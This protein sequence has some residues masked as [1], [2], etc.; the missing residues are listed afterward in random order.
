MEATIFTENNTP[1][2][3]VL[4]GIFLMLFMGIILVLFFYFSKKKIIQKELEKKENELQHSKDLLEASIAVQE[5]ERRRIAQDLHD[6]ISSKLNVV[7]LN[8]HLLSIDNLEKEKQTEILNTILS[9]S[10]KALDS[11]RRIAHNLFP[12]VFD[13][14]GLDAAIEELCSEFSSLENVNVTYKSQVTFNEADKERHLH[15][16]RI[17]QELINNSVRHGKSK[18]ITIIFT[19][20]SNKI[21]CS[22]NDNGVGFNLD[23]AEKQAGLGMKNIES[24]INFLKGTLKFESSINKG[25]NAIFEF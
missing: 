25:M 19:N 4:T 8:C 10:T 9:L 18:K 11:S 1:A 17:L 16:F 2:I 12:P 23:R 22:Y 14:F 15:V 21:S 13:K 5:K 3:V 20:N 6:D 7:S 24:R